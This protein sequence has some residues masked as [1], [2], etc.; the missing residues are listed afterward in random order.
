VR[1]RPN[2]ISITS[3]QVIVTVREGFAALKSF[4][5][6]SDFKQIWTHKSSA[7][8]EYHRPHFVVVPGA[9]VEFAGGVTTPCA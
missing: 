7:V 4:V 2:A 8:A 3:N 1:N 9:T 6:I 5:E